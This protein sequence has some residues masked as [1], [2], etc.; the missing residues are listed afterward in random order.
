MEHAFLVHDSSDD[1]GVAVRDV[2]SGQK[3]VC[4]HMEGGER[5]VLTALSDIPLGHKIA[6]RALDQETEVLKYGLPIG[7]TKRPVEAG[8]H[9]HTQNLRTARW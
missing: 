8:D 7:R 1:V 4:V 5:V 6:L 9:V 2:V 3:V